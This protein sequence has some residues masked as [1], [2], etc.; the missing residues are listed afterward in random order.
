VLIYGAAGGVGS[1][2]VQLAGELGAR[3]IGTGRAADR[4][5][6]LGLGAQA[7]LD[8]DADSLDGI[9]EIDVVFDV[10]GG[11]VLRAARSRW[12]GACHCQLEPL[13]GP[14]PGLVV[15]SAPSNYWT[16]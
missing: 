15:A 12:P 7:F 16:G 4:D 10:I 1:I 3:V 5:V 14:V 13:V 6:V 11:D 2:A 9:G 8:L